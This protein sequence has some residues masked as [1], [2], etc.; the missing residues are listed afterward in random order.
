[1]KINWWT[2][3]LVSLVWVIGVIPLCVGFLTAL[4]G[5]A[6]ECGQEIWHDLT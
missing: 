2:A 6:Y 3:P 5:S 4:I 1:M